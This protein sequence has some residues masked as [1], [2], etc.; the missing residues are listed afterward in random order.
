MT[1]FAQAQSQGTLLSAAQSLGYALFQSQ[2]YANRGRSNRDFVYDCYKAWLNREPDQSGWDFWTSAADQNGQAAV[3]AGFAWSDEFHNDV[4]GVCNVATFDGDHDG[5]PDNFENAVGDAFTPEYHVSYFETDNYAT[6][7]DSSPWDIKARYGTSPVS[8]FRVTPVKIVYNHFSGRLESFLRIDYLSL[9]D[10]DSGLV[11]DLCGLSGLPFLAGTDPH[12]LDG[13]RSAILVSAPAPDPYTFNTDPNA[14]SALSIFTAAHEDTLLDHSAYHDFPD[15]PVAAGF[16]K[17]MWQSLSKH[18]TYLSDPDYFPLFT[19]ELQILIFATIAYF[20]FRSDC[21]G[22]YDGDPFW[23]DFF[24]DEFAMTC[25]DWY[26]VYAII[27]YEVVTIMYACIVERFY[28]FNTEGLVSQAA[29]RINFGEPLADINGSYF[30]HDD[31]PSAFYMNSKLLQP[32]QF[33]Y[34]IP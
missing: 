32:L 25:D 3:L 26:V 19:V 13:E 28:S 24:G 1:T 15:Q 6:F 2:E 34:T 22:W 23:S 30:I 29:V 7:R 33:E 12:P 8:Y 21:G 11:G 10:Q 9:W 27:L 4:N 14:Y 16:H 18:G 20:F 5:L 31:S 17:P